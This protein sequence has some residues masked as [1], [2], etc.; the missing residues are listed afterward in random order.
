MLGLWAKCCDLK[1][2]F[3]WAD[4]DCLH[5]SP[6]LPPV[7]ISKLPPW[8]YKML[9]DHERNRRYHS[10][11][12]RGAAKASARR[13]A[14]GSPGRPKV[15]DCGCGAGLLSLIAARH[16]CDVSAVELS[17][18]ISDVTLETFR[19]V[20]QES[21]ASLM[22]HTADVRSLTPD[23]LESNGGPGPGHDLIVSELM[24]ASG[25]GESLLSVLEHACQHLAAPGAQVVPCT[26]RLNVALAYLTL[27]NCHGGFDFS[28]LD[29][30]SFCSLRGGPFSEGKPL[31]T[32]LETGASG[33]LT[34][35]A[36]PSLHGKGPFTSRNMNRLRKGEVWDTLTPEAQLLEV[37]IRRALQGE[38]LY[39]CKGQVELMVSQ[40]GVAN[41]ILWWWEAQLDEH[42]TISNKPQ[43]LGSGY[44]THWHQPLCPVGPIPVAAGDRLKLTVE[45]ADA[46][47]QKMK[48][49]LQPS[50]PTSARHWKEGAG[51]KLAPDPLQDLL[52]GWHAEMEEACALNSKLT[53]K[54]TSRGDL[55]GLAKLQTAVLL[56]VLVPQAF[57]C[58]PFIRD[59]L[60]QTYFGIAYK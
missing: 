10:A 60:L 26:L 55:A 48:F 20:S 29:M 5:A 41:C 22:L 6:L 8:H 42:E 49:S 28:A 53:T 47:G 11:I 58:D 51:A 9:N 57:G 27:P 14:N 4:E 31:P 46:A 35:S 36:L 3:S 33:L 25:V 38:S 16:G 40:E 24:D 44:V 30:I 50:E 7:G 34:A 45:I 15:L 21:A 39:P 2:W 19:D 1:I 23:A 13:Q 18:L 43:S 59:R 37:D 17:P 54:F 32:Q 12:A 52:L 56:M